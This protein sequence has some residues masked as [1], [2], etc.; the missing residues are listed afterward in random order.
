[1]VV[2]IRSDV[3]ESTQNPPLSRIPTIQAVEHPVTEAPM[4]TDEDGDSR[5]ESSEFPASGSTANTMQN[6]G[7]RGDIDDD[8]ERH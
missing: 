7:G 6:P 8:P 3:T 4:L 2:R 1:M 5:E